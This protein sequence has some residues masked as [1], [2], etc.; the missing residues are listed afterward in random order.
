MSMMSVKKEKYTRSDLEASILVTKEFPHAPRQTEIMARLANPTV[1]QY[2][3]EPTR[4]SLGLLSRENPVYMITGL[5]FA[6]GKIVFRVTKSEVTELRFRYGI[7]DPT[8]WTDRNQSGSSAHQWKK[9]EDT[10][11]AYKLL[12]IEKN[13]QRQ[14]SSDGELIL[15][16]VTLEGFERF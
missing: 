5:K 15:S 8:R 7:V 4:S 2:V 16:E 13:H 12:K 11:V 6:K 1:D 9:D 3:N 10:I 14:N